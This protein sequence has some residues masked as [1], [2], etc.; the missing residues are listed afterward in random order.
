MLPNQSVTRETKEW[1]QKENGGQEVHPHNQVF[2][3]FLADTDKGAGIRQK[4]RLLREI[5]HQRKNLP[6]AIASGLQ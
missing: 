5:M 1:E 2:L 6:G 3:K 4:C